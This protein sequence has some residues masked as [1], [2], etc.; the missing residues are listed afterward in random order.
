MRRFTG[1]YADDGKARRLAVR[2]AAGHRCVRCNHPFESGKH[3]KGEWS[4]CDERCTHGGSIAEVFP[5]ERVYCASNSVAGKLVAAGKRIDARW[6]ILT[7]HH[8]DGN[9]ANDHWANTLA[10][11]QVCHLEVQGKVDPEIPYFLE[12]SEWAKPYI[13]GFYAKKYEGRLITREE[14]ISRMEEILNYERCV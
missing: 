10:L 4:P 8:F 13:S 5:N 12:H 6:R 7:V 11:C 14:A 2:Q 3:G 9:K 1:Q